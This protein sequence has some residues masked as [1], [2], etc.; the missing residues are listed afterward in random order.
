MIAYI[1]HISST[2]QR[3]AYS[4]YKHV[5]I[6]V[7]Q[8]SHAVLYLYSSEPQVTALNEPVNVKSKSGSNLHNRLF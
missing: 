1:T 8:Q 4:M 3:V 6:A 5:G 2:E 7:S